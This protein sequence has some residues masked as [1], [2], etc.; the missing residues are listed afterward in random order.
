MTLL[1]PGAKKPEYEEFVKRNYPPGFSYAEFAP[2]FTA[3]FYDPL[4]WAEIFKNSGARY[5]IW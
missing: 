4:E 3:E 1:F 2:K 5:A